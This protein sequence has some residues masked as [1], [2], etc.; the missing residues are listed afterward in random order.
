MSTVSD[1]D[2]AVVGA[3]L[4]RLNAPLSLASEVWETFSARAG[5]DED[6]EEETDNED[7]VEV[8]CPESSDTIVLEAGDGFYT[9]PDCG[10]DIEVDEGIGYH[11]FLVDCPSTGESFFVKAEEDEYE[12]PE[13]SGTVMV[14]DDSAVHAPVRGRR[15]PKKK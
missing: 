10:Q 1:V 3:I 13:C 4:A 5:E 11:P 2:P 14:I 7:S 9:C 12:C 8:E 15:W 6:G